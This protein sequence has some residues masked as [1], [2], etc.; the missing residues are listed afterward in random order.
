MSLCFASEDP[1]KMQRLLDQLESGDFPTAFGEMPKRQR[2][3]YALASGNPTLAEWVLPGPGH[4]AHEVNPLRQEG[5]RRLM[6]L[7][8]N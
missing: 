2:P 1:A 8:R 3:A 4:E 7:W 6:P 5:M